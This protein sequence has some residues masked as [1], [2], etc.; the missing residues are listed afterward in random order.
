MRNTFTQEVRNKIEETFND[1]LP[2]TIYF[3]ADL[4]VVYIITFAFITTVNLI[5]STANNE[6]FSDKNSMQLFNVSSQYMNV[7]VTSINN[8]ILWNCR[9]LSATNSYYKFLY[10]MVLIA[11]IIVMSGFFLIKLI[12]LITLNST[13]RCKCCSC[14]SSTFKHVLTVLWHM[15]IHQRLIAVLSHEPTENNEDNI[16]TEDA[17]F[18]DK[19]LK[20]DIPN[21]AIENLSWCKN[22]SRSIIPYLLLVFLAAILCL[23]YLSFDLHPA[24][25]IAEPN[26][27][28]ITYKVNRVELEFSHSLLLYQKVGSILV[29]A[30]I[31]LFAICVKFF[32]Y[33][34]QKVVEDL[35]EYLSKSENIE[36]LQRVMRTV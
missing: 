3:L 5:S 11:M 31:V 21:D 16:S 18:Y 9:K 1:K 36:K 29:L 22:I 27:D 4:R 20:R 32:F 7:N 23:A 24:A 2:W 14:R 12:N 28:L 30:L 6:A 17:K 34:T 35:K 10:W 15:A 19:L 25:C 13:F 33:F 26:E 8:A